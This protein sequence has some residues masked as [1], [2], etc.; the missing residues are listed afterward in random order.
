[1]TQGALL[2]IALHGI[3]CLLTLLPLLSSSFASIS[4]SSTKFLK[5]P[6]F[7]H[8]R[9][10]LLHFLLSYLPSFNFPSFPSSPSRPPSLPP[11]HHHLQKQHQRQRH[12]A[13]PSQPVLY[14]D[15]SFRLLSKAPSLYFPI[16]CW[17]PSL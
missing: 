5:H 12:L 1:M 15:R 11:S 13:W 10:S 17:R 2:G 6:P 7:L 16:S 4:S 8:P 3:T 14:P 9:P